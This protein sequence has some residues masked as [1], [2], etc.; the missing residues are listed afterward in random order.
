MQELI[1]ENPFSV[2]AVLKILN[3]EFT[4]AVPTLAVTRADLAV[5]LETA[6]DLHHDGFMPTA[7]VI[8]GRIQEESTATL[9]ARL[10]EDPLHRPEEHLEACLRRLEDRA[11]LTELDRIDQLIRD[12]AEGSERDEL[13]QARMGLVRE[14]HEVNSGDSI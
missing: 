6:L 12:T 3:V 9:V 13:I 1:D 4:D 7:G 2:R 14:G 5:I 8:L 10:S 11:R